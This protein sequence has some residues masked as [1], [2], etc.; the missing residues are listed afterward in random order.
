MNNQI[1]DKE[2]LLHL[3]DIQRI[4][5]E[6]AEYGFNPSHGTWANEMFNTN[7]KTSDILTD[8]TGH[9]AGKTLGEDL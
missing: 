1:T 3:R 9:Y 4:I 6:A 2:I 8:R 7:K 5:C